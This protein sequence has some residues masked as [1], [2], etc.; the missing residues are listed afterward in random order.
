MQG[1]DWYSS[2][3]P[4]LPGSNYGTFS[5][6]K[7]EIV[8]DGEVVGEEYLGFV[9]TELYKDSDVDGFPDIVEIE[10]LGTDPE[11]VND[12]PIGTVVDADGDGLPASIDPDDSNVDTD[13]DG[14]SDF[15]EWAYGTDPDDDEKFPSPFVD[16]G[17]SS[18]DYS[19][20]PSPYNRAIGH[21]SP[22]R[23]DVLPGMESSANPKIM[24]RSIGAMILDDEVLENPETGEPFYRTLL[25]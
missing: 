8:V 9:S 20:M 18:P 17:G 19:L 15:V 13:G 22:Y 16:E 4:S 23:I 7:R 21:G 10:V 6:G 2:A 24:R 5:N 12:P 14:W 1:D 11:D 3:F 25:P